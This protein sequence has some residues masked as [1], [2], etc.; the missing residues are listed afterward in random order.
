MNKIY[1]FIIVALAFAILFISTISASC[2]VN[3]GKETYV[4]GETITA[5][6]TC[7]LATEK[8]KA[9]T[10]NWTYQNGT[11]V[12]I[13]NGTTPSTT[14]QFFY[15]SYTIPSTWPTG[16]FVN[17]SLAGVSL[18]VTQNDS[19]NVTAIATS[20]S[21]VITNSSFG[22]GYLGLVS[23]VKAMVK[24]EN[25]KKIS[26]GFCKISFWSNDETKMLLSQDT[27]AVDGE[28]KV[29]DILPPTRFEE[30]TDYAY[31]ILCYCGSAGSGTECIDENGI[32]VNNSIGS[33]KNFFTTSTWLNVNTIVDKSIYHLKDEVFVCANVT[34][35]NYSYRIPLHIFYQ[36]R[37]SKEKDNNEDTDRIL[38]AFN[39]DNKP[40]VR[41][42]SV[43]T[44]QM[45]CMKF[46]IPEEEYLMGRN[47]ECYAST[48][49]W[50]IDSSHN[51]L[52]SYSTSS[53]IFNVTSDE[54][55]L[56]AD[57]QWVSDSRIN[58]VINLS[59]FENTNININGTGVGN[60]DVRLYFGEGFNLNNIFDI[61]NIISNISVQNTTS[62][63]IEHTDYEIEFL[64]DGYLELEMRNVYLNDSWFNISIDFYD[65]DLRQTIALEGINNSANRSATALEGIEN[66][67]GTFHLAVDCPSYAAAG[68]NI[69]CAL[70]AKVEDS[71]IVQKE[72][73]FT[74]Y[75]YDGISNYNSFNFNQMIN[76]T[77]YSVNKTIAVPSTFT[78]TQNYIF[79]CEAG[80][81]NLGSRIDYFYDSFVTNYASL[82]SGSSGPSIG[83]SNP[84]TGGAI[85]GFP[86][87]NGTDNKSPGERTP[88]FPESAFGMVL[89]ILSIIAVLILLWVV[90]AGLNSKSEIKNKFSKIIL[91]A[92]MIVAGIGLIAY[93]ANLLQGNLELTKNFLQDS[94]VRGI[95]LTI[96]IAL[97]IAFLFRVLNIRGEIKFG[98][99]KIY[100]RYDRSL[101]EQNKINKE[102]LKKELE[103]ERKFKNYRIVRIN[104]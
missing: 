64:E 63:L 84:I 85:I 5:T 79:Q 93:L 2:T 60:I 6:M 18:T 39:P 25:G 15:Q 29:S 35:I 8:S 7:S 81:Y 23:S 67:T 69:T 14:G 103:H 76:H 101:K 99:D 49:V 30:G 82:S 74:C 32:S 54:I 94:L 96:F 20:N 88:I 42:I 90:I 56:E 11:V 53:S 71:Q 98:R 50:V 59:N 83:G 44:T 102:I 33:A 100:D 16:V 37:C 41:G 61:A 36:I 43:N 77:L 17:A 31:K 70:S 52:L 72:V 48:T 104:K 97:I 27:I 55:N 34:N 22:G 10:L 28:I 68:S 95:I 78:G 47:S 40:D 86:D 4:K 65:L 92:I 12:E 87:E 19:A 46:I 21:L 45:Q 26:G 80:Y 3:F 38:I 51:E 66:K 73:D 91:T 75:L 24:D 13:D 1:S 58:S 89:K 57:W 62:T 9:Y